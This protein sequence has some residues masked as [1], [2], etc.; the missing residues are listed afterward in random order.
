MVRGVIPKFWTLKSKIVF[1]V[2]KL[3]D[4]TFS[5]TGPAI[6]DPPTLVRGIV[7]VSLVRSN[8]LLMLRCGSPY[9]L[10]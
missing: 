4:G 7:R 6:A 9:Y 3:S 8:R 5:V 2:V 1:A 10:A